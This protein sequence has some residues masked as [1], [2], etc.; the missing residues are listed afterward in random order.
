MRSL[1]IS[2]SALGL[3][4][5]IGEL[6]NK[7]QFLDT[8]NVEVRFFGANDAGE[9]SKCGS[10]ICHKLAKPLQGNLDLASPGVA[11]R[12]R[13]QVSTCDGGSGKPLTSWIL[14][15]AKPSPS[16]GDAMP[17]GMTSGLSSA[18]YKCLEKYIQSLTSDG[19]I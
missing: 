5:C 16:C 7:E 8:C 1:A 19:G 11:D 18:D 6:D 14:E 15:K 4:G 12:L 2:L 17:Y 13:S 9:Q 10:S 3:F